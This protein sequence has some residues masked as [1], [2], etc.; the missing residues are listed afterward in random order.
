VA[1]TEVF[2]WRISTHAALGSRSNIDGPFHEVGGSPRNGPFHKTR[3]SHHQQAAVGAIPSSGRKSFGQTGDEIPKAA[4]R[5][6]TGTEK[7][8]FQLFQIRHFSTQVR[9]L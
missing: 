2:L 4:G 9:K 6:P 7:L 1:G 8:Q 3:T 5:N